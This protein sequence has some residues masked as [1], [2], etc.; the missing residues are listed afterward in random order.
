MINNI[1]LITIS[2]QY[3]NTTHTST[4]LKAILIIQINV[5][6]TFHYF[7]Y[8]NITIFLKSTAYRSNLVLRSFFVIF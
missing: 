1:L 5:T 3:D 8:K 7:P 2:L 4:G 6:K